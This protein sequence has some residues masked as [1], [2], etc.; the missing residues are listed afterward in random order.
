MERQ[1]ITLYA[2]DRRRAEESLPDLAR[3]LDGGTVG[4]LDAAGMVE[5]ELSADSRDEA[6]ARVRDA[7]AA[8]GAD[9]RFTF[10]ETTGTGH[11]PPGRRGPRPDERPPDEPPHLERGS[12]RED[13][14]APSDESP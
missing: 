14:P 6:L 8:I 1:L 9:E 11:A 4:A 3:A 12:P 10:P 2:L 5:I 13:G 7:I